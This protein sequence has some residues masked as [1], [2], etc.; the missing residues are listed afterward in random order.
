MTHGH[1]HAPML[2][3]WQLARAGEQGGLGKKLWRW[4]TRFT[5]GHRAEP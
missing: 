5:R 4:L 3:R 1:K 2:R